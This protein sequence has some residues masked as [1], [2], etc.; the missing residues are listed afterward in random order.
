[1]K[2]VFLLLLI[3]AFLPFVEV[4]AQNPIFGSD[5]VITIKPTKPKQ[6]INP[7]SLNVSNIEAYYGNGAITIIFNED[8]GNADIEVTNITTGDVWMDSVSGVC[9]T[10]ILLSGD[11]GHY[12]ITIYTS[13]C[14]YYGEFEL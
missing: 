6:P 2:K 14:D 9:N 5:I 13:E 12:S 7:F 8:L 10:S 4:C 3:A 11:A 1:M